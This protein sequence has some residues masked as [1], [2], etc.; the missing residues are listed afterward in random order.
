MLK[1]ITRRVTKR[2]CKD[3]KIKHLDGYHELYVQSNIFLLTDVF[4]NF[5]NTCLAVYEL[6]PSRFLMH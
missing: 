2:V 4:E 6:D 3:F 1:Q 5:Q